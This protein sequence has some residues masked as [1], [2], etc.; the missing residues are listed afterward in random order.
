MRTARAMTW[1]EDRARRFLQILLLVYL[2]KQVLIAAIMPPFSGHDELA[3]YQYIR[4]VAT[5]FRIPRLVD[6]DEWRAT[7]SPQDQTVA[8]DF[9][10]PD[11]YRWAEFT[12]GWLQQKALN[13]R[14]ESTPRTPIYSVFYPDYHDP[15]WRNQANW[16]NWPDGLVY[17]AN[18]PPLFYVLEAPLYRATDWMSVANQMIVLRLLA[19][20]FGMLAVLGTYLM[21]AW[22]FPRTRFIAVT[23]A[24]FIAF[25]P[26]ISYEASMINNDIVL[27]GFAALLMALLVRGMRDRFPWRLCGAIGAVFG[28]MLLSKG[29]GV[30]FAAPVAIMTVFGIGIRNWREWLPKGAAIAGLGFGIAAPWYIYLYRVY[31]NFSGLP[32]VA[33]LQYGATYDQGTNKPTVWELVWNKRFAVT[34]WNETWGEFGWRRLPFTH[35]LLWIIGIVCLVLLVLLLLYLAATLIRRAPARGSLDRPQRWQV[36]AMLTFALTG[37]LGYAAVIQFGLTFWLTQA[38]YFFP[39][40]PPV[41]VLLMTGLAWVTPERARS[42]TQVGTIAVLLALNLYIY[43]AYVVPFWYTGPRLLPYK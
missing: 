37:V 25:Q 17:T 39:M 1:P 26:Q 22:L 33:R 13:P 27:I 24:A 4:D 38:R 6:L 12:L 16:V 34:R 9:L 41:I 5:D 35:T 8:G 32:Q 43:S 15:G 2:C 40:A 14:F 42:Y 21:A 20:P 19:I 23:A 28:L 10:D 3:H 29:S 7:H 36:V 11:L 18:H 31:G 30:A